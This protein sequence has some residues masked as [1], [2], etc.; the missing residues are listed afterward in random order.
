[1]TY[2]EGILVSSN[3]VL[4]ASAAGAEVKEEELHLGIY[5][6]SDTARNLSIGSKFTFSLTTDLELFYMA[7]LTGHDEPETAEL[8]EEDILEK[9]GYSYPKKA[10][11]TYFCEV[12]DFEKKR[13]N[14]DYGE[15][16][17]KK[18]TA[19]INYEEGEE[20]YITRNNPYL[21]SMVY[22][23]RIPVSKKKQSKKIKKKVNELLK[24]KNDDLAKRITEYVKGGN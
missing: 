13:G 19:K 5:R 10:N 21:D 8:S 7:S 12:I 17:L 4:N 16:I 1:M 2:Y 3:K 20:E 23:S 14:D 11:K 22:A 18:I 24:N 15:F 6:P 9:K